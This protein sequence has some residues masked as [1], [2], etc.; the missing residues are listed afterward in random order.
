MRGFKLSK[1]AIGHDAGD[2]RGVVDG[3]RVWL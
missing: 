1:H 3:L 2:G